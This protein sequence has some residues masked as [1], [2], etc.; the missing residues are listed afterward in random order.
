VVADGQLVVPGSDGA[1]LLEPGDGPL[2][3]VALAVAHRIRL[4]AY[5][6]GAIVGHLRAR[7]TKG[8]IMPV[9]PLVLSIAVLILRLAT[10]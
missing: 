5:F 6:V 9:L 3:H 8:L 7:D 10:L 4:V 2:D 1:V